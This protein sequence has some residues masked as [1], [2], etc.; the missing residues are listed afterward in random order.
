MTEGQPTRIISQNAPRELTGVLEKFLYQNKENQW[1]VG[2]LKLDRSQHATVIVGTLPTAQVGQRLTV[3]GDFKTHP[4]FGEQFVVETYDII[5]PTTQKGI[6]HYLA[7]GFIKGI[8]P[9]LAERIVKKFGDDTLRI[10]DEDIGQLRKVSGIGAAKFEELKASV[11]HNRELRN[12]I[13]FFHGHGVSAAFATRI[14]KRYQ[15]RTMEIVRHNPYQLAVDIRGIGFQRADAIAM[16]LGLAKDSPFRLRAGILFA[17]DQAILDGHVFF[18]RLNLLKA[19]RALLGDILETQI[20]NE[21]D[22]LL[23]EEKYLVCD[24]RIHGGTAIYRPDTLDAERHASAALLRL[25]KN[26]LTTPLTSERLAALIRLQEEQNAIVFSETQKEAIHTALSHPI[27]VITGGPGTGKTTLIKALL[28]CFKALRLTVSLAAPTG[29]AAKR[30]QESTGIEAKTLHRLLEFQAEPSLFSRN[31][32]NPI[33]CQVLIV[34]ESSMIDIF[35]ASAFLEALPREARL[36]IVGDFDQLPSVGPGTF[37]RDLILSDAVPVVRLTSVFRQVADSAIIQNAERFLKGEVPP[38]L[39]PSDTL[40]DFYF[41]EATTPETILKHIETLVIERI[42]KRF[43]ILPH[44]IQV[45]SP[46]NGGP[47]GVHALNERLQ[48]WI[49][50]SGAPIAGTPFR[51]HDRVMQTRNNYE[52][53]VF[54]GDMGVIAE[55]EQSAKLLT[56]SFDQKDCIYRDTAWDE[57][58]LA[59]AVSIHKSQGSEFP[60]IIVP[61]TSHHHIML[62]RNLL[63]TA[64]TRAK[65]LAIFIG[66]MKALEIGLN[67]TDVRVRYSGLQ[68]RLASPQMN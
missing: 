52:L 12:I 25:K 41:I 14:Y 66:S 28:A 30:M 42:P 39:P 7:S 55:G 68:N 43:G 32:E 33:P 13:V 37:L 59:Y 2:L 67:R 36:I 44:D 20:E 17:L 54:N 10:L 65:H 9:A 62:E 19:S 46:M 49:N 21:L 35:L 31:A 34:D 47:L 56:V 24:T 22:H 18:P 58:T 45:L 4:K 38:K 57:L 50:P 48:Q 16:S 40:S 1:S 11:H 6:E 51:S 61:V 27:T 23:R 29:R 26:T 63:Y 53:E 3:T 8:G 15:S 64:L 5:L 60:A